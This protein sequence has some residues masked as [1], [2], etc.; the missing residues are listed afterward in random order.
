MAANI[1]G[2][3]GLSLPIAKDKA[4]LP[5]GLQLLAKPLAE[6]KLLALGDFISKT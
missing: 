1:A 4:N 6:A 3:C 5:I 2:I